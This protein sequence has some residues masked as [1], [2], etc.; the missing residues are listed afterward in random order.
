[1]EAI[2]QLELAMFE[3]QEPP[4]VV[5]SNFRYAFALLPQDERRGINTIYSF[6][7][8]MDDIVDDEVAFRVDPTN[9][10]AIREAIIALKNNP[11]LRKRMSEACLRKAKQL[12]INERALRVTKWIN[13]IIRQ[14]A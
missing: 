3:N 1:M 7:A 13:E 5:Q 9:V 4:E 12:D 2:S 11:E 8:Y 6:C 10:P 14:T